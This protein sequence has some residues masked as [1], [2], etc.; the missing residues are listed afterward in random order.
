MKTRRDFLK[1]TALFGAS[2][3]MAPSLLGREGDGD[4][5]FS[6][7][8]ASSMLVPMG[9]ALKITG[10]FLDEISHDIPHQNWGEREWDQ[11]FRYMQSIGIDTVIGL[12]QI[13]YLSFGAFAGQRVLYA[14]R[15]FV[16]HVPSAGGEI[17]HEVLFWFI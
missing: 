16:G 11:D 3:F 5:F 7:E 4:C 10:T 6:Q 8:S 12:S 15:R 1:R 9:D 14:F 13:H 17:S 2:A